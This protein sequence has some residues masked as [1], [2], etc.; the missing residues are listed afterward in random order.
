MRAMRLMGVMVLV[1]VAVG[2][3]HDETPRARATRL[4]E[5]APVAFAQAITNGVVGWTRTINSSIFDSGDNPHLWTGEA[6][7]EF[8]NKVGGVE[9]KDTYFAFSQ[10][11][12]HI[13]CSVTDLE[14]YHARLDGRAK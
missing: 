11:D 9:R 8:V 10:S 1:M 5:E 12:G 3:S 14:T 6:T 2:C 4:H 13:R 7:V